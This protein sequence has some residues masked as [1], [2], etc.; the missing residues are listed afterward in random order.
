MRVTNDLLLDSDSRLVLVPQGS[1]L[2]PILF[3]L[4]MLPLGTLIR[5]HGLNFHYYADDTQLSLF[6]K[7]DE[8]N[9]L[10][11]LQACRKYINTWMTFLLS[12]YTLQKLKISTSVI[13]LNSVYLSN[14][15]IFWT[16]LLIQTEDS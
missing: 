13:Y 14:Q 16:Y 15:T 10:V 5:K 3:T 11:R 4:Y 9:Q 1:V 6:M 2:G 8:T 7:P 12:L